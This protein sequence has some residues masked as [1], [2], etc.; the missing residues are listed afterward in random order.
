M[1]LRL[2]LYFVLTTIVIADPCLTPEFP[3]KVSETKETWLRSMNI[4]KSWGGTLASINGEEQ[5][6]MVSDI[7]KLDIYYWIGINVDE[8]DAEQ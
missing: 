2:V 8:V 1:V 7:M 6:T 4:C 3:Y 5:E